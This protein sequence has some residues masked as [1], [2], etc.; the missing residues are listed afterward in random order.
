MPVS[1]TAVAAESPRAVVRVL[2]LSDDQA[3]CELVRVGLS[4]DSSLQL[5]EVHSKRE[6]D[7]TLSRGKFDVILS[8]LDIPGFEGGQVFETVRSVC[9]EVPV[10]IIA[11]TSSEGVAVKAW[12][13][14]AADHVIRTQGEISRLPQAITSVLEKRMLV[15]QH[16]R[17][18]QALREQVEEL[19]RWNEATLGRENRIRELKQEV[20]D[21]LAGKGQP[22][23]YGVSD[24]ETES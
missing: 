18:E 7:E 22:P 3:D 13:H 17:D 6:F 23:R 11:G 9:P 19:T 14:G 10:I 4:R 24:K 16:Q 1:P 21:L 20:N 15:I 2:Y 12:Q 8:D 5:T